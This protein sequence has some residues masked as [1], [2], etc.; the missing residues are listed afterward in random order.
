MRSSAE[1]QIARR[2]RDLS[3]RTERRHDFVKPD[4]G[5][6][7]VCRRHRDRSRSLLSPLFLKSEVQDFD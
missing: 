6:P 3:V 2:L 1:D 4:V 5:R 7:A